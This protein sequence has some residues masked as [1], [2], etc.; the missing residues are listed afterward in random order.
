MA[1]NSLSN[2]NKS[3]PSGQPRGL[4]EAELSII[5]DELGESLRKVAE[6]FVIEVKKRF[7][8]FS[9]RDDVHTMTEVADKIASIRRELGQNGDP[10]AA[11]SDNR[12]RNLFYAPSMFDKNDW[13]KLNQD[14]RLRII[15][16]GLKITGKV[17]E[18]RYK[19]DNSSKYRLLLLRGAADK[20]AKLPRKGKQAIQDSAPA[21]LAEA[22]VEV[23]SSIP[24]PTLSPQTKSDHSAPREASIETS[25]LV[26][27][28]PSLPPPPAWSMESQPVEPMRF[29]QS[30]FDQRVLLTPLIRVPWTN[31][32]VGNV[33]EK[34]NSLLTL[35]DV[36]NLSVRQL[37][38]IL[39][40]ARSNLNQFRHS[41]KDM[42]DSKGVPCGEGLALLFSPLSEILEA[43]VAV[44]CLASVTVGPS[45]WCGDG[46]GTDRGGPSLTIDNGWRLLRHYNPA[47]MN[48]LTKQEIESVQQ[49]FINAGFL[50]PK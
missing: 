33:L 46:F 44:R 50:S 25:S 15:S 43:K 45:V 37:T 5:N 32:R 13:H 21:P 19:A 42:H 31:Q 23:P 49:L 1:K 9:T 2:I 30:P 38:A 27:K 39:S 17:I 24:A 36:A 6:R 20:S 35:L 26:G 47:D 41:L 7:D 14:E 34:E 18:Q 11:Y 4:T 29:P 22:Q 8:P 3:A 12:V 16:T 28:P 10:D 48:I 40:T